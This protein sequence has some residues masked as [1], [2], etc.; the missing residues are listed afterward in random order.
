MAP[1]ARMGAQPLFMAYHTIKWW[2]SRP[3]WFWHR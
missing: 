3:K 2:P 1:V